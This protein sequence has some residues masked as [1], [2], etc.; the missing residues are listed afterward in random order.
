MPAPLN[1]R[2]VV[3][4][5]RPRSWSFRKSKNSGLTATSLVSAG[6]RQTQFLD[7]RPRHVARRHCNAYHQRPLLRTRLLERGEL[8]GQQPWRHEV[9]GTGGEPGRDHVLA[10]QQIDQADTFAPGADTGAIS[11]LQRRV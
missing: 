4:W 11:A 1:M 2:C 8:A 9:V 6:N 10:A 7:D 3:I 5:P